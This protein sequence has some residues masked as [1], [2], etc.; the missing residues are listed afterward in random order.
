MAGMARPTFGFRGTNTHCQFFGI[1]DVLVKGILG[2]KKRL[3]GIL[4][5]IF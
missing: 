4:N 5:K 2:L 3:L 1:F